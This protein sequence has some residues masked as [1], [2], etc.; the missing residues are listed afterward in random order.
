MLDYNAL[1]EHYQKAVA[2]QPDYAGA[3]QNLGACYYKQDNIPLAIA[4]YE[5][6]VALVPDN[7]ILSYLLNALKQDKT[8]HT[9]W[10]A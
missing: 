4:F 8:Q 3:L 5:K 2:L 1:I 10:L 6:A 9:Q 7:V